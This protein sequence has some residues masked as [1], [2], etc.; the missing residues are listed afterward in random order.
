MAVQTLTI[1][2]TILGINPI[3][4]NIWQIEFNPSQT[5]ITL[6][7][8]TAP[9]IYYSSSALPVVLNPYLNN[10]GNWNTNDYNAIMNNVLDNRLNTKIQEV[11]YATSQ[12]IPVNFEAIISAII[13]DFIST[14]KKLS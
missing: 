11:D 6:N 13:V 12:N 2:R 10:I 8:L 7:S 14:N 5:Q 1:T 4:N 3:G 9:V